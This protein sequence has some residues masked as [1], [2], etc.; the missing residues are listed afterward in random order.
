MFAKLY[1][2]EEKQGQLLSI[3][4]VLAI[5]IAYLG[6][7]GLVSYTT[8]QRTKEIGVRKVIGASI[9]Q[10]IFLLL[11]EFSRLIILANILAIPIGYYFVSKWLENFAYRININYEAFIYAGGLSLIIAFAT[12]YYQTIKAASA[13]PVESLRYE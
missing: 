4:S 11:K 13:N 8:E 1:R 5:F 12:V 6:L 3:F 7:F 2:S 9:P 10:I